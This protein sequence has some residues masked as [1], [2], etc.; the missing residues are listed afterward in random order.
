MTT[1]APASPQLRRF[2]IVVD[3]LV[4]FIAQHWLFIV[5]VFLFIFAGLPVLAPILMHY[6]LTAPA[7]L[8]YRGYS[9]TCHQLSERTY[10][11]FG[12]KPVYTVTELE[13]LL[14]VHGEDPLYWRGFI[15][16]AELG[17]KMAWCERD[18]AIYFALM[19]AGIGFAFVRNTLKPLNWRWYLLFITPMAIDGTWQLFTS[20][21][22]I[23]PFLPIHE[24]DWLLRT[25]TGVLFGIGSVWLIYPYVQDAMR[26]AYTDA[27][28]QLQRALAREAE[29]QQTR[30]AQG[31]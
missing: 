15:G 22:V 16:N 25:I 17:Y 8:I 26:D 24:S 30:I 11:F 2:I 5:N 7:D 23:L 28:D 10:F 9:L 18:H 12:T 27:R 20:P 4:V 29:A 6:G 14:N 31:K 3:R 1:S 13:T 21:I 19:L